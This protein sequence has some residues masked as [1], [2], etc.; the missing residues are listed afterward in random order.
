[1]NLPIQLRYLATFFLAIGALLIATARSVSAN[2]IVNGD[3]QAGNLSGWDTTPAATGSNFGVAGIPPAHDTLGAYFAANGPDFDSISQTFATTPGAFY[4][5]SFFYQPV[6]AGPPD[7]GFRALF[8]GVAIYENFDSISGFIFQTFTVQAT[9]SV[10]TLE[11]QGRNAAGVDFLDDV[12]VTAAPC[13]QPLGYWKNNPDAWPVNSL[14]LGSQTYTKTELLT[15]L[16]TAVAGDASLIL[17]DQLIAAKLNVAN[18]AAE[19]DP[20]PDTITDADSL[21]SGFSG[22]LPYK[23]KPSSATGQ[24]MVNDATVLNN[25][26]NGTLTTGC[27]P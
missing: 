23:V 26:N 18:G 3:F 21:L 19:P 4:D 20:V 13:P 16:K 27:T 9:G 6:S 2:L 17:A 7:N 14:M 25:Y 15:I 8:N 24:A 1:M 10:T 11:F 22:K 5:V 12:S